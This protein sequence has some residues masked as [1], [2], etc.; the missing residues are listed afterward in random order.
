MASVPIEHII[1]DFTKCS[2]SLGKMID[3][4][5]K[6][7]NRSAKAE[8]L[9][10]VTDLNE[11][12]LRA[13]STMVQVIQNN[14]TE[15]KLDKIINIME[16]AN[17]NPEFPPLPHSNTPP[18]YAQIR[19]PKHTETVII[20]PKK[21]QPDMISASTIHEMIKIHV[22]SNK[23]KVKIDKINK[24]KTNVTIKCH[25]L[26]EASKLVQELSND[27]TLNQKA[28]IFVS[29][30]QNPSIVIRN[31]D[32]FYDDTN[33]IDDIMSYNNNFSQSGDDYRV[34]FNINR[35]HSKDIVLRVSPSVYKQIQNNS[36]RVYLPGQLCFANTKLLYR[37]CQNCFMFGHKSQDCRRDC[38]CYT[39]GGIK[40][41]NPDGSFNHTCSN[42]Q[43]CVNCHHHNTKNPNN[44]KT[45]NHFPNRSGCSYF[46]YNVKKAQ[47]NVNYG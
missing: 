16:N 47:E 30:K 24:N 8:E 41:K 18:G 20:H 3:A 23:S 37:Q 27:S 7:T 45:T 4:V 33:I 25:D 42:I 10:A 44:Q 43:K 21:D 15:D 31:V 19:A 11:R 5:R 1:N 38:I 34:L 29:K 12:M 14:D 9:N 28:N 6:R 32:K 46:D 40:T 36:F 13:F 35:Q 22:Y 26:D 39:C 17:S 2:Q